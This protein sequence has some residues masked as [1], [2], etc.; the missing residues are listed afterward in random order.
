MKWLILFHVLG[1]TIWAGGHLILSIG[2]LPQALKTKDISI[3]LNFESRYE[4]I[5]IPALLIQV[6][7][8]ISMALIYVP[9]S[10]WGNLSTSH[11][12]YLWIKLGL[13]ISTMALGI[14][15]RFF[16]IPRLTVERLSLLALHVILI[17]VLAVALVITGLSFRFTYF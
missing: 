4:R 10:E 2:F 9:F 5:G 11:H 16:I 8:G 3:I 15:A 1:A 14:H 13:L 17:T 6:I 12:V 7:T